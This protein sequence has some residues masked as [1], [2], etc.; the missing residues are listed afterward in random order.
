MTM[1]MQRTIGNSIRLRRTITDLGRIDSSLSGI[2]SPG[3][4]PDEVDR[5]IH[6]LFQQDYEEFLRPFPLTR[7]SIDHWID[8]LRTFMPESH[9]RFDAPFRILD[10]GSGGGTTVFPLLELYPS[11]EIIASDLSLNLLREL[12]QWHSDHHPNSGRLSLLQLNA[13]NTVFDDA[14]LDIV[15][16]ADVLHHL[17]DLGKVF[18]EVGRI[19]KPDGVA[20]FFEGFESG[21]QLL[22]LVMQLL[23]AKNDSLPPGQQMSSEVVAIFRIFMDDLWRRKGTTKNQALLDAIDDKWLFTNTQLRNAVAGSGLELTAIKQVYPPDS[24]I[25]RM[26]DHELRRRLHTLAGL[27]EWAR[28]L[29]VDI[30]RQ[31]SRELLSETLF[32]GAIQL[33]KAAS[34]GLSRYGI[35]GSTP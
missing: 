29:V 7:G 30:E 33:T 14:Q 24:L 1:N 20:L 21:F 26:V 4:A 6:T 5:H 3:Y 27:P 34:D 18:E 17:P 32:S 10:V 11:A 2:L 12:H 22:S 13:E 25:S 19:L 35:G 16:G 15:M 23:I 9:Q 31:F 8:L 28:E